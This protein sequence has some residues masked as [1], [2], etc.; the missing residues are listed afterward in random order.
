MTARSQDTVIRALREANNKLRQ[1]NAQLRGE[2]ARALGD[3]R[4]TRRGTATPTA[5][6]S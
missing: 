5:A 6:G 3:L 2:L 1:E 4:D